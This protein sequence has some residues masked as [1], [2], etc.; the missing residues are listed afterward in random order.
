MCVCVHVFFALM[1]L[2][3][4][5]F[6]ISFSFKSICGYIRPRTESKHTSLQSQ[7]ENGAVYEWDMEQV[8]FHNPNRVPSKKCA[9][10]KDIVIL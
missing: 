5:F 6:A 1:R 3:L 4:A 2:V 8:W 9:T 7:G 10:L